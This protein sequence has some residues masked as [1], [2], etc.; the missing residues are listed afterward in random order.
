MKKVAYLTIG[1]L[2]GAL[3]ASVAFAR[4]SAVIVFQDATKLAP[5][6]YKVVLD[7]SHVRV[8]D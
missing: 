4:S 7:N 6:M 3:L 8:V 1:L 2:A 5:Q